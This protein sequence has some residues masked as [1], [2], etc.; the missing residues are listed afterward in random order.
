MIKQAFIF[1]SLI[2]DYEF[3]QELPKK[4]PSYDKQL[5]I[6]K[7]IREKSVNQELGRNIRLYKKL[8][9][10][11]LLTD[12]SSSSKEKIK[13]IEQYFIRDFYDTPVYYGFHLLHFCSPNFIK[14]NIEIINKQAYLD[15][16]KK[17]GAVILNPLHNDLYQMLTNYIS[18]INKNT[19]CS[20]YGLETSLKKIEKIN[21]LYTPIVQNIEYNYIVDSYGVPY[22]L[23]L[24]KA[25]KDIRQ[26]KV[27]AIPPEISMGLGPQH[28]VNLLGA[29]V[30]MPLGSSWV[31][32]KMQVPIIILHTE[33]TEKYKIKITFEDPIYPSKIQNRAS[34]VNESKYVFKKIDKIIRNHP[35]S[36]CGYD[37]FDQMI[38]R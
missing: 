15:S 14:D 20:L 22:P 24:R 23:I 5:Q 1:D 2:Q 17:Y 4:Y 28:T 33:M 18:L 35:Y 37:T 38:V 31:S 11:I 26:G 12:I 6:C 30:S 34:I 3:Y 25:L 10:N 32:N 36:W 7:K 8:I 27:V 19:I 16:I 9:D 13:I 21:K 29:R